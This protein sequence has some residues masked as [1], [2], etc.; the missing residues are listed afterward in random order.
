MC[1]EQRCVR[2][3]A[4]KLQFSSAVWAWNLTTLERRRISVAKSGAHTV[5]CL[6][7]SVT[8]LVTPG[9]YH[10]L[11]PT[12]LPCTGGGNSRRQELLS[13]LGTVQGG[14]FAG[15]NDAFPCCH[16]CNLVTSSSCEWC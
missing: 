1:T 13:W 8:L 6:R 5:I 15:S 16:A 4:G 11:F 10:P 7:V 14:W 12:L 9:L 3:L 2:A